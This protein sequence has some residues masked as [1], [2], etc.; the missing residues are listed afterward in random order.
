MA[1]NRSPVRHC[2]YCRSVQH[3]KCSAVSCTVQTNVITPLATGHL[4][5]TCSAPPSMGFKTCSGGASV[6]AR[7]GAPGAPCGPKCNTHHQHCG[8]Y[9]CEPRDDGQH[10]AWQTG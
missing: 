3:V 5:H 9:G 6:A 8:M 7:A 1:S 2:S 4:Q 10:E